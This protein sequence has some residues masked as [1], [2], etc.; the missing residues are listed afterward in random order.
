M[1]NVEL[2]IPT[3]GQVAKLVFGN[4]KSYDIFKLLVF[5]ILII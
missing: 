2:Y 5:V 3:Y 1:N 4:I